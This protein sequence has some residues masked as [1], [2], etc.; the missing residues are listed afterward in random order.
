MSAPTA[1]PATVPAAR[2]LASALVAGVGLLIAM[3][4]AGAIISLSAGLSPTLLDA[5]GPQARLSAPIPMMI[6]QVLLVVGATRRRRGVAVPASA[7]LIVAG[8][9]AFM[10]GFYDGGYVADLTAGQRVF[11]IALVTAHLGV[12]VLAGFRLV[13][14]LRR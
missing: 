13:R 1:T 12:G 9:L 14:L 10:S 4:V 7:L 6:A 2:P 8:V 11:Q 5:L 3:D